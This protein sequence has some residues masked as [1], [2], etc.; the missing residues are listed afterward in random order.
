MPFKGSGHQS[1]PII[2]YPVMPT[3]IKITD[4]QRVDGLSA[5][6]AAVE[7]S[8][9]VLAPPGSVILSPDLAIDW[10]GG[11]IYYQKMKLGIIASLL[12][13]MV[14]K[15]IMFGGGK[16]SSAVRSRFSKKAAV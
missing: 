2:A 6:P 16:V 5:A 12:T 15:G 11:N 1:P 7:A 9:A 14:V 4:P 13:G 10:K 3:P 8:A